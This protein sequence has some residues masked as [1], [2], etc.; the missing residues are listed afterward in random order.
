MMPQ[1]MMMPGLTT[2][3]LTGLTG[4]PGVGTD[5]MAVGEAQRR[6]K[7]RL[8]ER[9]RTV[10]KTQC[11]RVFRSPHA[12]QKKVASLGALGPQQGALKTAVERQM[13]EK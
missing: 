2:G 13:V 6:G 8:A 9:F 7:D 4:M 12:L 3:G 10:W 5:P 1:M 11:L